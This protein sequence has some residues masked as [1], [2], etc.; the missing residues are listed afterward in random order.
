MMNL[1]YRGRNVSEMY[2]SLPRAHSW[3]KQCLNP[4]PPDSTYDVHT[5]QTTVGS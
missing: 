1:L 2:G 5:P 4:D 3:H